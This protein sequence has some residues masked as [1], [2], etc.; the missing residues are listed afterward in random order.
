MKRKILVSLCIIICLVFNTVSISAVD[1]TDSDAPVAVYCSEETY[2]IIYSFLSDWPI[3]ELDYTSLTVTYVHE[4]KRVNDESAL[5]EVVSVIDANGVNAYLIVDLSKGMVAEFGESTSPYSDCDP[6]NTWYYA[7]L[8][9]YEAESETSTVINN[10]NSG[11][12]YNLNDYNRA[13]DEDSSEVTYDTPADTAFVPLSA[14]Y[15]AAAS[16]TYGYIEGVPDY[17]QA[18]GYLCINTS[19]LNVIRYWD[20]NGFSDLIPWWVTIN[21]TRSR[22]QTCLVNNGGSGSNSSIPGAVEEYVETYGNY[23]AVVDNMWYP[24]FFDLKFEINYGDPCLVGFPDFYTSPHM[25]TGVGYSIAGD[26]EY[27]IVH[28]NH[29][30]TAE[31]VAIPFVEVDFISGIYIYDPNN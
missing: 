5:L 24:E 1:L 3:G 17:Q 21:A 20:L 14:E 12:S 26:T 29:S 7:P 27:V 25:T 16:S 23:A 28:D 11:I 15:A 31:D 19:L 6:N 4:L 18:D 8:Q 22:I 30:N 9:Y 10:L 2:Q 13:Y